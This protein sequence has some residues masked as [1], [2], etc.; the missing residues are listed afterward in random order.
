VQRSLPSACLC[1][2]NSCCVRAAPRYAEV[3]ESSPL[4]GLQIGKSGVVS[5]IISFHNKMEMDINFSRDSRN[6]S[7][8]EEGMSHLKEHEDE[9]EELEGPP[10][11]FVFILPYLDLPSRLT[12]EQVSKS[13]RDSVR[14]NPLVWRHLHVEP[15]ALKGLTDEIVTSLV[16]RADG[17]L[18]SLSVVKSYR[19]TAASLEWILH[20]NPGLEKVCGASFSWPSQ[21]SY[22]KLL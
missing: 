5:D 15:P 14:N 3:L 21:L 20:A 6:C 19:I 17:H 16:R 18:K 22:E 1:F 4:A 8:V 11:G 2:Q 7:K 13:L 10:E 12:M 9:R